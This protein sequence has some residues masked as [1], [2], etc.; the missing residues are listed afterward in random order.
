[1]ISPLYFWEMPLKIMLSQRS[2]LGREE[3]ADSKSD[4]FKNDV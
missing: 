4:T 2:Y 1:M 3:K